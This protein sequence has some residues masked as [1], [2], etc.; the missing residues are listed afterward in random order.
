MENL[1]G[2]FYVLAFGSVFACF[3]GCTEALMYIQQRARREKVSAPH[4]IKLFNSLKYRLVH[5]Y[6]SCFTRT[7]VFILW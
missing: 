3:Y 7:L 1:K 5:R 6:A 4:A 2:V